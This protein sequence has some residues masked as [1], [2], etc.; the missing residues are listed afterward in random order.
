MLALKQV[1]NKDLILVGAIATMSK[2]ISA[3]FSIGW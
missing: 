1:W 3:L 2:D